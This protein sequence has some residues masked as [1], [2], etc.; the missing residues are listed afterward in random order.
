MP[1]SIELQEHYGDDLQ[2][3]FVES[4]GASE[5]KAIGFAYGR[6]WMG[7]QAMWT[8]E[9]PVQVP[10][11]GLPKFALLSAEGELLLQ[12]NPLSM[13]KKIEQAID[14]EIKKAKSA[15]SGTPKSLSKAWKAFGKEGPQ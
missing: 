12:G 11:R 6:K 9:R 5:E 8:R 10:G 7:N 15:P 1:A 2:V 4:Q 3:I 14:G 13:K